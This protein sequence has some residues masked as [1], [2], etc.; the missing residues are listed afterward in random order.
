MCSCLCVCS[1]LLCVCA[2]T[3]MCSGAHAYMC[4]IV[5]VGTRGQLQVS[6]S[7]TLPTSFKP[8]S[9]V[10]LEFTLGQI[11]WSVSWNY[12]GHHHIFTRVLG[13]KLTEAPPF[14]IIL[15]SLARRPWIQ[16]TWNLSEPTIRY[17]RNP[18]GAGILCGSA[19]HPQNM[20]AL[21]IWSPQG[22]RS[23]GGMCVFL[24]QCA[25]SPTGVTHLLFTRAE[26]FWLINTCLPIILI[27]DTGELGRNK[28]FYRQKT[29]S[30]KPNSP[31]TVSEGQACASDV[32]AFSLLCST[33]R[34]I[35]IVA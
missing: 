22:R 32:P 21:V 8:V 28:G 10:G 30:K 35:F 33:W 18:G 16:G 3:C 4:V 24:P 13:I 19:L 25:S 34:I 15:L 1:C 20:Q 12:R 14:C 5:P 17:L 7:R 6:F 29:K 31:H 2:H 9:F 23:A 27:S 26:K 11:G